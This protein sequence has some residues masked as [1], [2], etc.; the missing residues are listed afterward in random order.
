[1]AGRLAEELVVRTGVPVPAWVPVG[2]YLAA[3]AP[4]GGG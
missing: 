4:E 3:E 1:M 2:S